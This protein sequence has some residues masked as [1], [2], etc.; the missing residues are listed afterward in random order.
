IG[1]A[2]IPETI[3]TILGFIGQKEDLN[4]VIAEPPLLSNFGAV[5]TPQFL[6]EFDIPLSERTVSIPV[7]AYDPNFLMGVKA[8]GV[9]LAEVPADTV[10][11]LRGELAIVTIDPATGQ[12]S[13]HE[14]PTLTLFSGAN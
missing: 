14:V 2:L 7:G 4:N 3:K 12:K 6:R 9:S 1:A 10:S 8:L 13:S 5:S 11:G